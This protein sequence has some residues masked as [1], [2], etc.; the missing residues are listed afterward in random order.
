MESL[1]AEVAPFG[2]TTTIVNPGFF[3]TELLTEQSTNMPSLH[4][5][6]RKRRGPLVEYWKA[7]NGQQSGDP[8]KLARALVTIASEKQPPRRFIAGA[9]AIAT[10]EQ[11][12]ADLKRRSRLTGNSRRHSRSTEPLSSGLS[13]RRSVIQLRTSSSAASASQISGERDLRERSTH[14]SQVID[15]IELTELAR[16]TGRFPQLVDSRS[17]VNRDRFAT[18]SPSLTDLYRRQVTS[19]SASTR[20]CAP[21]L[22]VHG[23]RSPAQQRVTK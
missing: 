6:L 8:A 23:S 15:F 4:R 21:I 12:I 16:R 1:Q 11:K 17:G 18:I 20:Q 13:S 9:D 22:L 2:I 14:S 5:R 19:S 7:Q 10:A 3:R